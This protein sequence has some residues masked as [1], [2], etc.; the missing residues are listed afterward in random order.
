MDKQAVIEKV[1]EIAAAP[2]CCERLKTLCENWLASLGTAKEKELSKE[3]VAAL[4]EDVQSL[5]ATLAFMK[6][7]EAKDLLG[8]EEAAKLAKL[9][10]DAKAAGSKICFCPACQAG[11][12]VLDNRSV[13]LG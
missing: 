12:A 3:L 2:S 11:Q 7:A 4:E 1:K 6:S 13:L 10:E 8:A 5:D 9:G